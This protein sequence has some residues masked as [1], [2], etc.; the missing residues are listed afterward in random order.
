MNILFIASEAVP[1]VKTGGL[2]DVVGALPN[3]LHSE[4]QI[5]ARVIL[6]LYDSIGQQHRDQMEFLGSRYIQL[7]WRKIYCGLF[8]L[9]WEGVTY[10]FLDNEY[11][12]KRGELYGHFDDGE[13]FAFFSKAAAEFSLNLPDYFPDVIHCNDWQTALVPV[14]LRDQYNEQALFVRIVFTIHNIEYQGRYKRDLLEDVFG[15]DSRWFNG[16]TM[17]FNGGLNLMKAAIEVSDWVTTVSPQY[18][19]ELQYPFFAHGLEGVISRVRSKVSGILNGIDTNFYNP[20]T[21]TDLFANYS[22]GKLTGKNT[23]KQQIQKFLGLNTSKKTPLIVII[24][25]LAAH[26][27]LDLVAADLTEIMDLDIQMVILGRGEWNF[28]QQFLMASKTYAGRFSAQIMYNA[29]LAKKLYASA[30]ILLMPSLS[31]P[32]GLSQLIAMRYGAVP[33]VREVGG[34]KDTVTPYIAETGEGRGFTFANY[35][36]DDMVYVLRQ[37]VEV[38]RKQPDVWA[39]IVK[40]DMEL[41]FSWS[42]SA[43][44]Y[45]QIYH[46]ITEK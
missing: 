7:G 27:G 16:G 38:Y 43:S 11:Y 44:K 34:L 31:E 18:A 26:K 14:Y 5:D 28:E 30:D 33:L 46:L 6:P 41:D 9:Q 36:A 29:P 40:R 37:A 45:I 3:N 39:K 10:Y 1:F 20:S 22:S 12:F 19:E 42:E 15:L 35:N 25:R 23:N 32:C 2:A 24:S 13:R 4:Y 21:D 8:S 17:E